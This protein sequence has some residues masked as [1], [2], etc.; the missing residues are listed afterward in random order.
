MTQGNTFF[1]QGKFDVAAS[2]YR[3]AAVALGP[4]SVYMSNLAAAL[5]K[6]GLYVPAVTCVFEC[7]SMT[8]I[9]V[10]SRLRVPLRVPCF[11]NQDTSKRVIVVVWLRR[12]EETMWLQHKVC[13]VL[14]LCGPC[15]I[16]DDSK[17]L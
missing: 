11:T 6:L 13:L 14:G 2:K 8:V 9:A 10:I 15:F 4:R 16:K 12:R 3:Q 5:L 7:F 17:I 1:R